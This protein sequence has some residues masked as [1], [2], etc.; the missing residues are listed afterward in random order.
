MTGIARAALAALCCLPFAAIAPVAA[1]GKNAPLAERIDALVKASGDEVGVAMRTLDGRDEVMIRA[2]D[3]FHAASTMKVPV[4]IELFRQAQ[5]G[6]LSLDH[7]IPVVNRFHSIVDGSP[8]TLSAADDSETE[9][10]KADGQLRSYRELCE[11]MI[12]VSS[13][14]ATNV[15]IEKLGVDRIRGTVA[16]LGARGMDVRRG[17]EDN[18]AFQA[19]QNNATTAKAL[20]V[21][22]EAIAKGRAVSRDASHD[23]LET[24]KR[25]KFNE[26]IPA[27]LPPGTAVA[28]KTGSI[29]KIQHDAGI[30]YSPRPYVLVVLVRGLEDEKQGNA[31]IAS[32]ARTVDASVGGRK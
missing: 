10:Y 30:V 5:A 6:Q 13:N 11:L 27:G 22:L 14:L 12:T 21:L 1:R 17:V 29:T 24:L 9:L 23:M 19:G 28:H 16:S 25:Q 15:L 8:Y 26:G 2:G 20:L 31:L 3:S 18:V 4:M 7:Q 32:I